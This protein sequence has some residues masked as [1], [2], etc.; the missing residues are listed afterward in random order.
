MYETIF[1]DFGLSKYE[2]KIYL[3]LIE[4]GEAS[5]GQILK[6]AEIHTG[7]I[8]QILESLKQKGFVSEVIKN[9]VK[10]FFPTDPNKISKY[11]KEKKR[12][13]SEQEVLFKEILPQL[14]KK[15][16][17]HK[18]EIHI[19]IFTGFEGMKKAFDKEKK[20]YNKGRLLR[21]NGITDY[22]KHPKKFIDYF[23][24]N[25][26]PTREKS[27]IIIHK[28]IDKNAGGNVHEKN[29]LIKTLEYNSLITFNTIEDLAI[30]SIWTHEPVFFVVESREFAKGLRENFELLW[31]IARK[32]N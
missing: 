15:I 20:Y 26:F 18:S 19:E 21:I 17:S 25:M 29:V 10:K 11:F 5:T 12:K 8:Y 14:N 24:F 3:A 6:K 1:W 23:E 28:I 31:K 30:I 2:T 16:N 22:N 4:I 13:I 27:G 7:K 32:I 9:G